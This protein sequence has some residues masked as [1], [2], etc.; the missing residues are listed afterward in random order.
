MSI[1]DLSQRLAVAGVKHVVVTATADAKHPTKTSL[2]ASQFKVTVRDLKRAGYMF[3]KD[4]LFYYNLSGS[5]VRYGFVFTNGLD[6]YVL[7]TNTMSEV[8]K[9][10]LSVALKTNS[11]NVIREVLEYSVDSDLDT[12][13]AKHILPLLKRLDAKAQA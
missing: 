1:H 10:K 3:P 7:S 11:G 12:A 13:T 8:G 5:D 4:E 9:N 6:T 2:K